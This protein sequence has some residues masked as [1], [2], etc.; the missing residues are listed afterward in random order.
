MRR[1]LNRLRDYIAVMTSRMTSGGLASL[2]PLRTRPTLVA[3]VGLFEA[4]TLLANRLDP[5]LKVLAHLRVSA[6]VGCP[7]CLDLGSELARRSGISNRQLRELQRYESSDAFDD[8]ERLVIS[9]ASALTATPCTLDDD[10][11][12]AARARFS[13]CELAELFTAVAWENHLARFNRA[14]RISAAGFSS[15]ACATAMDPGHD[16][17]SYR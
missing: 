15:G 11:R 17:E 9:L 14:F 6:L 10:L 1:T 2:H 16:M 8:D 13:E 5:R 12:E 4:A 3:A 7:Y